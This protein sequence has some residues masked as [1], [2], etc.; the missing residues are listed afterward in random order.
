MTTTDILLRLGAALITG[1]LL[2]L[3]RESHGRA[4]GLRTTVL[5]CLAATT[6]MILSDTLYLR[7]AGL[8]GWRPDPGRLGAGLLTGIGFLGGGVIIR[9]GNLVR[10]VTTAS[11]LW[12]A[13]VLGL[14]FGCGEFV[15][16]GGGVAASLLVLFLL[17]KIESLVANDWYATLTVTTAVEGAAIPSLVSVVE[18]HRIHVKSIELA[19][20]AEQRTRTV[21]MTLKFKRGNLIELPDRAV[22]EIM[23][24]TGV[25]RAAWTA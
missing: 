15:L 2:G 12:F 9:Q 24:C 11:I 10:G 7:G 19:Q 25:I 18:S 6:A 17:P 16:G 4:A 21:T 14:C 22:A 13:T 20:D 8:P 3:E 23:T 5:V 1:I